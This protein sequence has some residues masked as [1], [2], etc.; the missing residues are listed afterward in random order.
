MRI[1]TVLCPALALGVAVACSSSIEPEAV[2]GVWY[3]R[4]Y[5]DS[6]VP[7]IA[8]FRAG[9]DSSLIEI[10]S[11]RLQLNT[12]SVCGWLVDLANQG[13]NVATTCTWT[14]DASPDDLM[15]TIEEGFV[16]RG[17]ATSD[18]LLLEDPN[19]NQLQFGREPAVGEPVEPNPR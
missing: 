14:V 10:D 4:A 5:N 19:G 16:L 2:E 3:L 9:N 8:V 11:V 18:A 13:P 1:P 6:A 15:V 12:A 7:G 17:D